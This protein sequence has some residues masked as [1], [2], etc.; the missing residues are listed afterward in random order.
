MAG[1]DRI[2]E[3]MRANSYGIRFD[4]LAKVC[5]HYFG[6]PRQRGSHLFFKMPWAGKPLVNIQNH[7]G[8][9]VGYQVRQVLAAIDNLQRIDHE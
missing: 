5:R 1:V 7:R 3:M 4:D 6:E 9:A 8:N 2:V